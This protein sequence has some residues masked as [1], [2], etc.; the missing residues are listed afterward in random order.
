MYPVTKEHFD[1]IA[2]GKTAFC[3]Y[4]GASLP[5]IG[6]GAMLLFYQTGGSRTVIGEGRIKAL[7][8][9]TPDAALA[10]YGERLF[11][12]K[13]ELAAYSGSRHRTPRSTFMV[14]SLDSVREFGTPVARTKPLTMA[15]LTLT[16]RQYANSFRHR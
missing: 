1:R 3:K 6:A 16:R 14:F 7:E 8:R 15:G 4:V 10:K 2:G 12:T 11:L 5:K 9:T 13:V